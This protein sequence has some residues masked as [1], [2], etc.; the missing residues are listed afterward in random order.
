ML[1]FLLNCLFL[2]AKEFDLLQLATRRLISGVVVLFF[3]TMMVLV[4]GPSH[5]VT[6]STC[7]QI[8]KEKSNVYG[9]RP[10]QISKEEQ[11]A[12]SDQMDQFWKSVKSQE[13]S[14]KECLKQLIV[15][16]EQDGFFV[17]DGASLLLS[18]DQS[19]ASLEVARMA[20]SKTNLKD[21]DSSGY[22]RMAMFLFQKGL[23]IT[24][25]VEHSMKAPEVKGYVPQHAMH[26]DR[27]TGAFFLY[28]IMPAPIADKSLIR[29]L[30]APEPATRSTA[31]LLLS[32][33]LTE[34][35]FKS[36]KSLDKA[37]L[38]KSVQEAVEASVKYH[39]VASAGSA[40]V[41]RAD[42]LKTL[43]R[44]PKYGGDF[45]GVAGDKEFAQS[46]VA[47]LTVEDIPALREA[48]RK[49]I[50][51]LSDEALHEY[52]ALSRTLLGVI[53]RFD[54]YQGLRGH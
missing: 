50:S 9:F 1:A 33:S 3:S 44:I 13:Q 51:G 17:F 26:L 25:A 49:S 16:E 45:W 31:V 27:E 46:S 47:V 14:G 23:D 5:A 35:S 21:I 22:I 54:L 10:S 41:S 6:V 32:L 28:G 48:R 39:S 7:V 15:A 12:K 52:F 11:K 30:D 42:V 36:L 34:E 20:L 8:Q 4:V 18:F 43:N 2:K 38:P 37:S 24:Q 53:N 19:P 40:K 29:M